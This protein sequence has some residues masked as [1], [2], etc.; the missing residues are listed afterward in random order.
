MFGLP[1][2]RNWV[3]LAEFQDPTFLMNTA[4]FELGRNIFKLPYTCTY[5]H[6]QVYLNGIY[7]GLY[8][9]TEHKQADPKEQGAPGRP[10]VDL[11][12]GWFVELD[13]RYNEEPK[14]RTTKYDLPIMIKSPEFSANSD[15]ERFNFV[16]KDWNE[17]TDSMAA[18]TFPENG[19]RNLI[20]M[21]TFIDFLMTQEITRNVDFQAPGSTFSYK[22]KGGKIS[23]G[24]LW[25]F[26]WGYGIGFYSSSNSYAYFTMTGMSSGQRS[27]KHDFFNRFYEDPVFFVKYKE[28]WNKKHGEILA[29][30]EFLNTLGANIRNAAW[31]DAKRWNIPGG[32][33]LNYS[34]SDPDHAKQ[35]ERMV[36]WWKARAA[37]L[38]AELNKVDVLPAS[39]D[40]G[41]AVYA[42]T[43]PQTFTLVSYGE[44][45]NLL[46]TLQKD[47]ESAFEIVQKLTQKP[48]GNGGYLATISVRPK[49]ELSIGKYS[50]I[51]VLSGSNQGKS[52]SIN[53]PLN[54]EVT[55]NTP[56]LA[57]YGHWPNVVYDGLEHPVA[58]NII[59]LGAVTVKYNGSTNA[60]IDAGTYAVSVSTT[61]NANY[62]A[63]KDIPLGEFS[64]YKAN[65]ATVSAPVLATFT[66]NSITID[67]VTASNGQEVEYAIATSSAADPL[68]FGVFDLLEFSNLTENTEYYIF[69]RTKENANYHTGKA[70]E[71]LLAQTAS[72]QIQICHAGQEFVDGECNTSQTTRNIVTNSNIS[73]SLNGANL[74]I[75]GLTKAETVRIFDLK[76][77]VIMTKTVSPSESVSIV[78]L[79]KGMYLVNVN[80]KTLRM[81][82]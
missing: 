26:D 34:E 40:F 2:A 29:V 23:M 15:D 65:G 49:E 53:V 76:G 43:P 51:L 64:I 37:F 19:Y 62:L 72:L 7:N 69:A 66:H 77:K 57:L 58:I 47:E 3:L 35:V 32:Y 73:I 24:P 82:K 54:F 81:V 52:F 8:G 79:P 46:A 59:G 38:H 9:F 28:R 30:S 13:R 78:H 22:D 36:N 67:A 21:E 14:F 6:V 80:G 56:V 33:R 25:D 68:V 74:S 10:K 4:A 71:H 60:P 44:M 70:S 5:H 63:L 31:E 55:K 42:E 1:A 20:D 50:D 11:N 16:K 45:T 75:L 27:L 61:G 48:T 41:T 17:L 12:E 39:K 18:Q